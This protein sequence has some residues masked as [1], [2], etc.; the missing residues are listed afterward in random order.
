[1]GVP[2]KSSVEI[3]DFPGI[4]LTSPIMRGDIPPGAA[5]VQKNCCCINPGELLVRSGMIEVAYD[6][7]TY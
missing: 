3:D 4:I 6:T 2:A 7:R 5:A 1:M